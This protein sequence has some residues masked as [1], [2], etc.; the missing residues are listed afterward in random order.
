MWPALAR[1][2]GTLHRAG[3]P[4]GAAGVLR[5]RRSAAGCD[6]GRRRAHEGRSGRD[7]PP[8]AAARRGTSWLERHASAL[9]HRRAAV[10]RDA[11]SRRAD[12]SST[13]VAFAFREDASNAMSRFRATASVTSCCRCSNACFSRESSTSSIA[14]RRL[15]AKMPSISMRPRAP[16]PRGSSRARRMA[17]SWTPTR[18]LRE[19]AAIARRV[20]RLAQQMVAG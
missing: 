8:A 11:A 20:I 6:R 3:R 12:V 2:A 19:P 1:E 4:H 17:S 13:R 10:H 15:R 14:R 9:G 16:R 5:T 18:C 7:V